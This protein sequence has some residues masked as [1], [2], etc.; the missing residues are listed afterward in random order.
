M[1]ENLPAFVSPFFIAAT[2]LVVGFLLYA[3]RQKVFDTFPA[4]LLIFLLPLWLVL[5]AVLSLG[6]F[7]QNTNFFP[8]TVFAFAALPAFLLIIF[9]FIFYRKTF[10]ETLP[11]KILTILHIVRIPVEL[12]LFWLFQAKQIPQA[13]TFEGGNIDILS[14]VSAPIIYFFAFRREKTKRL[15]LIVWNVLALLLLLNIV[16]TSIVTF[17]SPMQQIAFEQ[18]NRAVMY[19]PYVWLPSIIVPVV[20]FSHLA[21][22]WKLSRNSLE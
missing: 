20:L 6:A 7:H 2:F 15:L 22:L 1:L 8:P 10:I 11:L 3:V 21:A 18:P 5:Q 14:G 19:F 4:K 16:I 9:Y 17:P 12:V 13:M